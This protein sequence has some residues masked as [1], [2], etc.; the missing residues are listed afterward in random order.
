MITC[1][2]AKFTNTGQK[3]VVFYTIVEENQVL[4]NR[5]GTGQ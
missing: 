5:F 1:K 2:Y 4:N 3:L